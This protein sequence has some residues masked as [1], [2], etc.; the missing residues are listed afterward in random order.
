MSSTPRDITLK[1][2]LIP[3]KGLEAELKLRDF[4]GHFRD[5]VLSEPSVSELYYHRLVTPSDP[6]EATLP[7]IKNLFLVPFLGLLPS[8]PS[9]RTDSE[10]VCRCRPCGPSATVSA[11]P[12]GTSQ[13]WK[14]ERRRGRLIF[15]ASLHEAKLCEARRGESLLRGTLFQNNPPPA[16]AERH[17]SDEENPPKHQSGFIL[18]LILQL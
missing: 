14:A 5:V 1:P 9:C 16:G 10:S 18:E 7:H 11:P 13:V 3:Q 6:R 12:L 8:P 2:F 17:K 15:H 4:E